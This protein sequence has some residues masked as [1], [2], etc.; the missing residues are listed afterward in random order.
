MS[1]EDQIGKTVEKWRTKSGQLNN[2]GRNRERTIKRG[3][4]FG[5]FPFM[6]LSLFNINKF[7]KIKLIKI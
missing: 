6:I 5:I 3:T 4:K 7:N 1:R 2:E